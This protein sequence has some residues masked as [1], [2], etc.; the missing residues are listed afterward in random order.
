M[1]KFQ[2]TQNFQN[3]LC[4]CKQKSECP[5]EGQCLKKEIVYQATVNSEG[6]KMENY[7]GLTANTFK[8]SF[9]GH[10][11]NF[12]HEN[13]KGTTLSAHI[14]K[15]KNENKEYEISWKILQHAK[16]FTPEN[17]QCALCTAEKKIIIFKPESATLNT[18]NELGAHCKHKQTKL[19]Y[20]KPRKKDKT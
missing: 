4:N 14:W 19:L 8:E 12:N 6:G 15:L 2:P 13:S 11:F 16:P 3:K 5:L 20:K 9:S 1:K 7:V 17:G 10:L 18:R